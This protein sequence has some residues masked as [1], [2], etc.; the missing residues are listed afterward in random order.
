MTMG[1]RVTWEHGVIQSYTGERRI[2][3]GNEE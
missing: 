3:Q 1:Q 2:K